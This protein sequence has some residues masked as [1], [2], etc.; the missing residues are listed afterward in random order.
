MIVRNCGGIKWTTVVIIMGTLTL[1]LTRCSPFLIQC[2]F[3]RNIE[4]KDDFNENFI[5]L[6]WP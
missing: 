1:I 5:N 3:K 2:R 6:R 4:H